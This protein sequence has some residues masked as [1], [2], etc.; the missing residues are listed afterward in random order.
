MP[1]AARSNPLFVARVVWAVLLAAVAVHYGVLLV[2]VRGGQPTSS[3]V[4]TSLLLPL[5]LVIAALQ[6]AIV[7]FVRRRFLAVAVEPVSIPGE[8]R[9]DPTRIFS[10]H[11]VCWGLAEAIAVFG[12]VLGILARDLDTPAVFFVWSAGMLL[13][14]RPRAEHFHAVTP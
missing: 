13:A 8:Q 12:L 10:L 7:W 6:S 1:S 5:L 11:V 4:L 14:L 9:T 3:S 2:L